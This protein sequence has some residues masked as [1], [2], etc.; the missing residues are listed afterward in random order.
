[1]TTHK[2]KLHGPMRMLSFVALP[3]G[4]ALTVLSSVLLRYDVLETRT[5]RQIPG[6]GVPVKKRVVQ[7]P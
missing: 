6:R 4:A 2:T 5:K 3:D 7:Q 1:M